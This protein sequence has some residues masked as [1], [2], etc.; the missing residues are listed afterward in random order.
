MFSASIVRFLVLIFGSFIMLLVKDKHCILIF[1]HLMEPRKAHLLLLCAEALLSQ[2]WLPRA[3]P[4]QVRGSGSPPV[5]NITYMESY[6]T[7][8]IGVPGVQFHGSDSFCL[9]CQCFCFC[10]HFCKRHSAHLLPSYPI[11]LPLQKLYGP[12]DSPGPLLFIVEGQVIPLLLLGVRTSEALRPDHSQLPSSYPTQKVI[13]LGLSHPAAL[14]NSPE[15]SLK[16]SQQS[17]H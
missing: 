4:S 16:S 11:T 6:K 13:P 17:T 12:K 10:F 5:K 9:V 8:K 14:T 7:G 3:L 1:P 2:D 15:P